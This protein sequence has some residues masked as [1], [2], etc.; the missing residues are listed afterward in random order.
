[1]H[2]IAGGSV[3]IRLGKLTDAHVSW[4]DRVHNNIVMWM[5]EQGI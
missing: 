2:M 1:M 4:C 5:S 3:L